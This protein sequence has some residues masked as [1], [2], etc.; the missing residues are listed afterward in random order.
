[1]NEQ[2]YDEFCKNA[3]AFYDEYRKQYPNSEEIDD[4]EKAVN[5]LNKYNGDKIKRLIAIAA[6]QSV[7]VTSYF[8]EAN[9]ELEKKKNDLAS[10]VKALGNAGKVAGAIISAAASLCA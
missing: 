9:A 2:Q 1:M 3:T 8:T 10:L 5:R 7:I 6:I 4:L